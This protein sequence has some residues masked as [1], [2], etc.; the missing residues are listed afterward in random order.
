MGVLK[1]ALFKKIW[2]GD[3]L[4]GASLINL[5]ANNGV[6][7]Y[8]KGTSKKIQRIYKYKCLFSNAKQQSE[9]IFLLEYNIS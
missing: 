2:F 9:T 6:L 7:G 1:I 3:L 8:Y 5:C 4:F